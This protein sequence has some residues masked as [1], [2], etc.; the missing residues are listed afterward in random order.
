MALKPTM[1][2]LASYY[3]SSLTL[4]CWHFV[5]GAECRR[6][7]R[8]AKPFSYIQI[9][10]FHSEGVQYSSRE[11]SQKLHIFIMLRLRWLLPLVTTHINW[12][13]IT[14]DYHLICVVI[15]TL[16]ITSLTSQLLACGLTTSRFSTCLD[17]LESWLCRNYFSTRYQVLM[18]TPK[19]VASRSE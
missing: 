2:E 17:R 18:K 6:E 4:D 19:T 3:F 12:F 5:V 14:A 16:T 13:S 11:I 9:W 15:V 10:S 8:T 7:P 1:E